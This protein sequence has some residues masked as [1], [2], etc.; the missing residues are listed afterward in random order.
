LHHIA[1]GACFLKISAA[2]AHADVFAHGNLH[3][4][5]GL[6]IPQ[7]LEDGVG[8]TEHHNVLHRFLAEIM[9]DAQHLPLTRVLHQLSIE[10]A[11]GLQIVPERF[12]HHHALPKWVALFPPLQQLRIMQMIH[13]TTKETRRD[14]EIKN[15]IV[16]EPF[17]FEIRQP[18]TKACVGLGVGEITAMVKEIFREGFP[19]L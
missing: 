16:G 7:L 10:F 14:G 15:Q 9:I 3:V 18:F 2:T 1:D 6:T 13:H 8:E 17:I 12:L 11:G 4:L 5:D 19:L